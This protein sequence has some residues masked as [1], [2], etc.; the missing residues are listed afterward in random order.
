MRV[1]ISILLFC[2]LPC[3]VCRVVRLEV[4]LELC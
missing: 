3:L 2:F 1:S 4:W